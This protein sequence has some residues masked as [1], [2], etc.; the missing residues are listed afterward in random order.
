MAC[1]SVNRMDP[2]KKDEE[3]TSNEEAAV[4]VQL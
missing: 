4:D 3:S 2:V 1:L